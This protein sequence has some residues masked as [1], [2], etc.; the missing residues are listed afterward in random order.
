MSVPLRAALYLRDWTAHD[1]S[2]PD[3]KHQGVAYCASRLPARRNL[4]RAGRE[5]ANDRRYEFQRRLVSERAGRHAST[6]SSCTA[7]RGRRS[8]RNFTGG[9][10][11]TPLIA[12]V[13]RGTERWFY[14][15]R[16][17][18]GTIPTRS[19]ACCWKAVG[20]AGTVAHKPLSKRTVFRVTVARS[21]SRV[22]KLWTG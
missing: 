11:R 2:I 14:D 10:R 1:V 22:R 21:A 19:K 7:S 9:K 8:S 3:Q 5:P 18:A 13:L 4:R 12:R 20:V 15:Y 17:A 6:S 16:S